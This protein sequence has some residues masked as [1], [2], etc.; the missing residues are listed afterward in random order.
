MPK[1][2]FKSRIPPSEITP[3]EVFFNRRKLLAAGLAGAASALLPGESF[4]EMPAE[5]RKYP[6][7]EKYSVDD[8]LTDY[9]DVTG[10]NNFYEFGTDKYDPRRNAQGFR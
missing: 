7:N 2:T 3:P 6:R 4:P 9:E 8:R 5:G 1:Q 10:Y